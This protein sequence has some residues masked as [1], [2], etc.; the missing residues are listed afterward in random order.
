MNT[1]I[2]RL[3]SCLG[4]LLRSSSKT[5]EYLVYCFPKLMAENILIELYASD[6]ESITFSTFL[7]LI[8]PADEINNLLCCNS[9]ECL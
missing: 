4:T 5:R 1:L 3:S 6:N 2:M 9:K 7:P 8:D